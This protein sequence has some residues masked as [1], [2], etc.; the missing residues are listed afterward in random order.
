MLSILLQTLVYAAS[1]PLSYLALSVSVMAVLVIS[2]SWPDLVLGHVSVD[3]CSG[4]TMLYT[5]SKHDGDLKSELDVH[6]VVCNA[7]K[8]R[9]SHGSCLHV[10]CGLLRT[11]SAAGPHGFVVSADSLFQNSFCVTKTFFRALQTLLNG[12]W[13]LLGA[14]G[15]IWSIFLQLGVH[16]CKF[17]ILAYRALQ[18]RKPEKA[19]EH[20]MQV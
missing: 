14:E 16:L 13:Q 3:R 10:Q 17:G 18:C 12:R 4:D 15:T 2:T 11:G 5:S 6:R 1:G 20:L 9:C 19:R 8:C 7:H